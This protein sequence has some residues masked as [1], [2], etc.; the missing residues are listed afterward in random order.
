LLGNPGREFHVSELIAP[1]VEL[2]FA[3]CV[4]LA[5]A[6]SGKHDSQMT[7][8]PFQDAGPISDARAKVEY[9]RRLA[10]LR[11]EFEEAEQLH[12]LQRVERL[13][14]ERDCIA[15]QL[16]AAVGLGGRNRKAGSVAERARSAVTKR[17]APCL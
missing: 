6:S 4:G 5:S 15:D 1:F 3:S 14:Q 2:P 16:V 17:L 8:T 11:G 9:L 7:T 10:E 12:D 13:Q